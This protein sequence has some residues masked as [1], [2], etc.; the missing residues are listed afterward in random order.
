MVTSSSETVDYVR[1]HLPAD[2]NP[3][4][5]RVNGKVFYSYAIHAQNTSTPS[6]DPLKI[7][8]QGL[9]LY[10]NYPNPFNSFTTVSFE[11]PHV[12]HISIK[13][14]DIRGKEVRTRANK[15][16]E[17]GFHPVIWDGFN[18]IEAKASSGLFLYCLKTEQLE[19]TRKLIIL[20]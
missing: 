14:Y 7:L 17:P 4:A 13:I 15:M 9:Q 18:D 1:A 19:E 12:S 2:E 10:Q 6:S 16:I 3:A 5:G 8:P 11:L 20:K